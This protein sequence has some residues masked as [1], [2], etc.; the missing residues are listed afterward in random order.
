MSED[1]KPAEQKTERFNL[2]MTPSEM[3]AIDEWAWENRI[4]SKPEAM[5]RLV[6]IGLETSKREDS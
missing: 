6:Q 4:R 3:K 5:R 2:F 1:K